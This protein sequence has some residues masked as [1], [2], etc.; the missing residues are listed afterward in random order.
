MV[1]Q[2]K[3]AKIPK[4]ANAIVVQGK[5]K[6]GSGQFPIYFRQGKKE[7]GKNLPPGKK[8]D[9]DWAD[10]HLLVFPWLDLVPSFFLPSEGGNNNNALFFSAGG[11]KESRSWKKT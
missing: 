4:I 6:E 8:D 1:L 10:N 9:E 5:K 7:K 2:E 11:E 3:G